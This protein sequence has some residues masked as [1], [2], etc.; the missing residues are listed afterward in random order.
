MSDFVSD[1]LPPKKR[2]QKLTNYNELRDG[3]EFYASGY[4]QGYEDAK[5]ELARSTVKWIYTDKEDKAY[6]GYCS[7]CKCDMPMFFEDW[8]VIYVDTDYCPNCGAKMEHGG[9]K[10]RDAYWD[11]AMKWHDRLEG[12]RE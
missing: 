5:K 6:G 1:A 7:N 2:K 4:K 11:E 9:K 10:E 8:K 3:Q 12:G